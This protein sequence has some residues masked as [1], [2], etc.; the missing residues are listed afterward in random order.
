MNSP[1]TILI[2]DDNQL[3]VMLATDLLEYAG[4]AVLGAENVKE[5]QEILKHT[6]P[7]LMLLDIQLPD[8]DGL[9]FT[10]LLKADP[11]LRDI[12]VVLLTAFAMKG[13][14]EKAIAVGCDGYITK[15]IDTRKFPGQVAEF[16][17]RNPMPKTT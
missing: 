13:D 5:A 2:V 17:Q 3:N 8:M 15:P 7:A 10:Q 6:K 9:T 4:Y 12:K 11:A 14:E 16:I 1:A